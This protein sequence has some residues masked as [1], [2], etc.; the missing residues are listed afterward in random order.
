MNYVTQAPKNRKKKYVKLYIE[1][2]EMNIVIDVSLLTNYYYNKRIVVLI[3]NNQYSLKNKYKIFYI[4]NICHS[5]VFSWYPSHRTQETV[6]AIIRVTY[7]HTFLLWFLFCGF[8]GDPNFLIDSGFFL[9]SVFCFVLDRRTQF[10]RQILNKPDE[11]V[12]IN[13]PYP[14]LHQIILFPLFQGQQAKLQYEQ[15]VE[16]LWECNRILLDKLITKL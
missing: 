15:S 13:D 9:R 2:N 12:R 7:C 6:A 4:K 5:I 14:L 8:A 10:V 11:L 1:N 3:I 16:R